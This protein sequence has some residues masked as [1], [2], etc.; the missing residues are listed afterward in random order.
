MTT[1]LFCEHVD[2]LITAPEEWQRLLLQT[3]AQLSHIC[4]CSGSSISRISTPSPSWMQTWRNTRSALYFQYTMG[5][6]AASMLSQLTYNVDLF[7]EAN[8]SIFPR[9][10]QC[11]QASVYKQCTRPQQNILLCVP[12]WQHISLFV[13]LILNFF[14]R[15]TCSACMLDSGQLMAVVCC[16]STSLP[17]NTEHVLTYVYL[18]LLLQSPIAPCFHVFKYRYI[19]IYIC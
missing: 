19:Y 7:S 8:N 15:C 9:L 5:P 12:R 1:G 6:Q 14:L 2:A 3:S 4:S 11:I 17:T 16:I 13:T 10:T 18:I